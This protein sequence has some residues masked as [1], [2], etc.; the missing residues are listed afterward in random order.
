MKDKKDELEFDDD[1]ENVFSNEENAAPKDQEEHYILPYTV[2]LE[3]PFEY[4]KKTFTEFVFQNEL[5]L[6]MWV[7]IPA[8]DGMKIGHMIPM[9]SG[10]T[11][12]TKEVVKKLR[13]ADARKCMEIANYFLGIG[14]EDVK[15]G[16]TASG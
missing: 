15:T 7:H 9:I 3:A 2:V 10:M 14:T 16:D 8:G 5:E 13:P 11:G 6:G 4:G 12:Q 1:K